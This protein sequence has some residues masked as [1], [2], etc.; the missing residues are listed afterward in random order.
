M[1]ENLQETYEASTVL[2]EPEVNSAFLGRIARRPT[3]YV[4]AGRWDA[5]YVVNVNMWL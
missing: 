3:T 1:V 4:D 5:E 2:Q